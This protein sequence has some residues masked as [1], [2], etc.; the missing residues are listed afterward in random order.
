[1][2]SQPMVFTKIEATGND[3]IVCDGAQFT[4][5]AL[6]E[7]VIRKLCHRRFGIGADGVIVLNHL[8][9]HYFNADGS[10]GEMCGNG[11][12]AATRFALEQGW[13]QPRQDILLQAD[14]GAH[15]V[16]LHSEEQ[17]MVEILHN[18]TERPI[19]FAA[20]EIDSRLCFLNYMN[21]GVPHVVLEVSG[22]LETI[23][24]EKIGK[25]IRN[26]S[27]FQP[28]GTN[29]NFLKRLSSSRIQI[30]TYERGVEAETLSCGTGSV[31]SALTIFEDGSQRKQRLLVETRGGTLEVQK[32]KT[33]LFLSGPAHV[34]FSGLVDLAQH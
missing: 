25:K 20:E 4:N 1:M 10:V 5:K 34:S 17:I 14:D 11:L 26:H 7:D 31:A 30:R 2:M 21:T 23:D 8:R 12:R 6:S 32:D 27:T 18:Q 16:R 29:V 22:D 13:I 19:S 33:G 15:R 24:V 28:K 9:M 3:F